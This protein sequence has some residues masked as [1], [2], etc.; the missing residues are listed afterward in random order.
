MRPLI[1]IAISVIYFI[2]GFSA[3]AVDPCMRHSEECPPDVK[4]IE[5]LSVSPGR[6]PIDGDSI[7]DITPS[8]KA[9]AGDAVMIIQGATVVALDK[10]ATSGK[11]VIPRD[12]LRGF[13]KPGAAILRIGANLDGKIRFY[14]N[15][16]YLAT[17]T[18]TI[19]LLVDQPLWVGIGDGQRLITL[20][21]DKTNTTMP[22]HFL[23]YQLSNLMMPSEAGKY[24]RKTIRA[25]TSGQFKF[26]AHPEGNANPSGAIILRKCPLGAASC[27]Q[28]IQTG[29]TTGVSD[30]SVNHAGTLLAVIYN[31]KV[32]VYFIDSSFDS[33]TRK[34]S[35]VG[36]SNAGLVAVGDITGDGLPDVLIRNGTKFS[37]FQQVY[38][39]AAYQL[40]FNADLSDQIN[41][42]LSRVTPQQIF[43]HDVDG[44]G[45]EDLIYS[46]NGQVG[47][48]INVG[49]DNANKVSFAKGNLV[50]INSGFDSFAIGDLDQ[51]GKADLAFAKTM[52]QNLTYYINQATY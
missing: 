13:I 6:L 49:S 42:S 39:T 15:P 33:S 2:V 24:P 30:I 20:S 36:M 21:D 26:S 43:I 23:E 41:T 5:S 50:A 11:V 18:K 3:C 46:V 37:L 29:Y 4:P 28:E 52:T 32:D 7:I 34:I 35:L 51:D 17:I 25:T 19:P 1:V 47:W 27:S 22:L 16:S 14:L 40:V 38:L 44:D 12:K 8:S 9:N 31:Q 10:I 48:I 45:L